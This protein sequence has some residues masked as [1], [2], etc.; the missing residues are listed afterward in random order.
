[1]NTI[2]DNK[3]GG[4]LHPIK[5]NKELSCAIVGRRNCILYTVNTFRI[6]DRNLIGLKEKNIKLVGLAF[7]IMK[8][9]DKKEKKQEKM[10]IIFDELSNIDISIGIDLS[11]NLDQQ[12]NYNKYIN[13]GM[14]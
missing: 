10:N 14:Q 2:D 8:H 9:K 7:A 12:S 5:N 3:I 1:M 6:S 11:N 13:G 4:Q